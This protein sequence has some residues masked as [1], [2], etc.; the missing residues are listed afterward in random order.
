VE[1]SFQQIPSMFGVVVNNLFGRPSLAGGLSIV[2]VNA[3]SQAV[4]V[5]AARASGVGS[6]RFRFSTAAAFDAWQASLG[7][8][9]ARS[10][11]FRLGASLDGQYTAAERRQSIANQ[12]TTP[13]GLSALT[14][15]AIGNVAVSHLRAT[16]ASQIELTPSVHLGLAMRTPGLGV[17]ATGSASLEGLARVGSLTSTS[18]FFDPDPIVDY[19]LPF[20][21]KGG[22]AWLGKRAQVEADVFA[23]SG[24]DPY[25]LLETANTVTTITDNGQG[26][27]PVTVQRPY[28]SPTVHFASVVNVAVG[29]HY[30]LTEGGAWM[31]HGGYATDRS[32]VGANDTA[33]TKVDLQKLTVGLSGRTSLFLGSLGLQY[34]NGRSGQVTLA[35]TPDGADIATR[36]KVS[37]FGLVYSVAVLF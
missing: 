36:F 15:A 5:E 37:S 23:Y 19:R 20:E 34:T 17:F 21:F 12:L 35:T 29:G 7:V 13:S 24:K 8:A 25:Q 1:G 28:V 32:P 18:S 30:T 3:W 6:N 9:Y 16:L 33:F 27:P 2:R 14:V 4:E 11:R 31:L 26:G 22:V 10:A